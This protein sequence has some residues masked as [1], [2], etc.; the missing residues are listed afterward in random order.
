MIKLAPVDQP[1]AE[2]VGVESE[3]LVD[4]TDVP[5][6]ALL[7]VD[8]QLLSPVMGRLLRRAD[9][10]ESITSGYNPQRLD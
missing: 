5:L 6:A 2:T 8:E 4:L 1:T 7:T 3:F 9:D 10:P